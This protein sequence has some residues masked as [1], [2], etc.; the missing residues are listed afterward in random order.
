MVYLPQAVNRALMKPTKP[1][2]LQTF[3]VCWA[4]AACSY[5]IDCLIVSTLDHPPNVPWIALG[6]YSGVGILF[7]LGFLVAPILLAIFD[8]ID[9]QP[10]R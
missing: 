6:A 3:A 4:V 9:S 10:R 7:T 1:N 2:R 5:L 8:R